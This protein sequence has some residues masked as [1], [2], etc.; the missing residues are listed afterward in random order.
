MFCNNCGVQFEGN[1]QLC[2]KCRSVKKGKAERS[3]L[4]LFLA[5]AVG[6]ALAAAYSYLMFTSYLG[7]TQP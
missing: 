5:L 1:Q 4:N 7:V 2:E 6:F 3:N